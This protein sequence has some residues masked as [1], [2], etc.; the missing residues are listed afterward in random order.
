M[1]LFNDIIQVVNTLKPSELCTK[2]ATE[3][4]Q[5]EDTFTAI[6]AQLRQDGCLDEFNDMARTIIRHGMAHLTVINLTGLTAKEII[7][8]AQ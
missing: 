6:A 7:Q 4:R 3:V 2:I 5:Q 8:I 1:R